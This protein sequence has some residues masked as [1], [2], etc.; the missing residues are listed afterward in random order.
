MRKRKKVPKFCSYG[1]GRIAKYH[2]KN[3]KYCCKPNANQCPVIAADHSR[4]MKGKRFTEEHKKK[5]SK[6]LK[7]WQPSLETRKNMS[8]AAKKR[9]STKEYQYKMK[10]NNPM[11][12]PK[13]IE[14]YKKSMKDYWESRI[15]VPRPEHAIAISGPNHHNWQGGKSFE[16]YC[17]VWCDEFKD[18]IRERDGFVC[19][20]CGSTPADRES[21]S[22]HHIDG[23][24][25]NCSLDNMI[26]LCRS[27][28]TR[29]H[30]M[31]GSIAN[32][33]LG[34]MSKGE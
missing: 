13:T 18:M 31:K 33:L 4:K 29:I 10:Y 28:H 19:Q 9:C 1:C 27:C 20:I 14:K 16:E 8:K 7:G 22:V 34:L 23:D 11:S 15:G 17:G 25:K 32:N 6:S 26:S 24:K 12:N 3:G 30:F 2:F 21:L 5:I